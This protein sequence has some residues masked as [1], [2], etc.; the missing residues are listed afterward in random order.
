[1]K[2][3]LERNILRIGGTWNL[4]NG[5]ITILFYGTWLKK[6]GI[7]LLFSSTSLELRTG[8]SLLDSVYIVAIGYGLLQIIIGIV[9]YI[10][11]RNMRNNR[12]QQ[13]F[14][15]WIS[16]LLI[17]SLVSADIMGIIIYLVLLIIYQARNK[18]IKLTKI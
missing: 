17:L 5:L 4:V 3:N 7:S 16:A 18:A 6:E 13:S 10:I 12:I 11:V 9:N 8:G 14:I 2:R 1:M 15:I